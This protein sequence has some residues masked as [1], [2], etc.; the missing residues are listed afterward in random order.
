MTCSLSNGVKQGGV[1]S[2]ILFTLY[3]DENLS[4]LSA[5]KLGYVTLAI[6]VWGFLV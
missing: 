3:I 6:F 1:L 4:Q 2:L 5:A